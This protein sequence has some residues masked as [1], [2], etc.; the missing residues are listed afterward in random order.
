MTPVLQSCLP[1][2]PSFHR[3]V[4]IP[5]I[6][7]NYSLYSTY[8]VPVEK[9]MATHSSILAWKIPWTEKPGRLQ[10]MESQGVGHNLAT[11]PPPPPCTR[12]G[13]KH[14]TCVLAHLTLLIAWG[15]YC[16]LRKLRQRDCLNL[17]RVTQPSNGRVGMR[18][19]NLIAKSRLLM[20]VLD[21]QL[22]APYNCSIPP[23]PP[24]YW[25]WTLERSL[26]RCQLGEVWIVNG[27]LYLCFL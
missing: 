21:S 14:F 5:L 12:H 20:H 25:S 3:D 27:Y 26:K 1:P 18:T 23:H 13:S 24:L 17:S 4:T 7:C 11:T 2:L 15:Y 19:G 16:I 10:S 6:A 22:P 8:S 9:E